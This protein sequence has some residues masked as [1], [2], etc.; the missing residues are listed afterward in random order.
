[1]VPITRLYA[2]DDGHARF[3]DIELPLIPEDPPPDMMGVSG[4]GRPSRS[5]SATARPAEATPSSPS[6]GACSS[7]ASPAAQITATGETGIFGPGDILLVEDTEGF[8]HSSR[9]SDGFVAAFVVLDP[10]RRS[11][12]TALLRSAVAPPGKRRAPWSGRGPGRRDDLLVEQ[13]EGVGGVVHEVDGAVVRLDRQ[14]EQRAGA[15]RGTGDVQRADRD[16]HA[17]R[18]DLDQ[19]PV[20]A[21]H[22][23]DVTAR[24]HHQP[25]L[26]HSGRD[27][28]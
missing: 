12:D 15:R 22:G 7:S 18:A 4:P 10:D 5:C 14:A 8:G 3:E 24:R 27:P 13:F 20:A 1:M 16:L 23:E 19:V 26:A 25:E 28:G 21:V 9:T 17:E 11:A 2:D 6:T